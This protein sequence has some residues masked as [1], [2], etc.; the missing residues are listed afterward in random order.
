MTQRLRWP[1][2]FNDSAAA[3]RRCPNCDNENLRAMTSRVFEIPVYWFSV[4]WSFVPC[5]L[6]G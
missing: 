1:E 2:S 6:T 4:N 3:T 5:G